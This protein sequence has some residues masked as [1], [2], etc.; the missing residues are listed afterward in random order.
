QYVDRMKSLSRLL[1]PAAIFEPTKDDIT[2]AKKSQATKHDG[3]SA[4]PISATVSDNIMGINLNS[5]L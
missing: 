4:L 2:E 5:E 1:P 3:Y